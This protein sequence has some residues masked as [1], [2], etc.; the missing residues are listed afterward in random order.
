MKE[1]RIGYGQFPTSY[2][3]FL[4]QAGY[5]NETFVYSNAGLKIELCKLDN[6]I[7]CC[8]FATLQKQ[9]NKKSPSYLYHLP[10]CL[11][12]VLGAIQMLT[13][14]YCLTV[15]FTISSL[16]FCQLFNRL[17][18]YTE[19]LITPYLW[20]RPKGIFISSCNMNTIYSRVFLNTKKTATCA[21]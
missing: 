15:H 19:W 2:F 13:V 11:T 12:L 5:W 4:M 6:L 1:W 18:K 21:S 7:E 8:K 10:H 20:S 9:R 3:I 14:W 17:E 16:K